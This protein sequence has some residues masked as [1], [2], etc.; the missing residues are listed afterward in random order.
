MLLEQQGL[1]V[2]SRNQ[3]HHNHPIFSS[4]GG[5][6][7]DQHQR[8]SPFLLAH[9]HVSRE[10]CCE[11]FDNDDYQKIM[12]PHLEFT[13]SSPSLVQITFIMIIV[14]SIMII[15][16]LLLPWLITIG[17]CYC[18]NETN[19]RARVPDEVN[20]QLC[21]FCFSHLRYSHYLRSEIF[22]I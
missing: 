21:C 3:T 7:V 22:I 13:N 10:R 20:L 18:K 12:T 1:T 6:T 4:H 16:T 11:S 5:G 8:A 17:Y 14:I 2:R 15:R 19:L 9:L